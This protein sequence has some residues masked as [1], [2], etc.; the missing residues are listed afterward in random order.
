L[1]ICASINS[2]ELQFCHTFAAN[3][4]LREYKPFAAAYKDGFK[5]LGRAQLHITLDEQLLNLREYPNAF[6]DKELDQQKTDALKPIPYNAPENKLTA[7]QSA[8]LLLSLNRHFPKL[9]CL[10]LRM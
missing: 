9:V 7:T 3:A 4:S 10:V 6:W 2:C 8:H 1:C 5:K